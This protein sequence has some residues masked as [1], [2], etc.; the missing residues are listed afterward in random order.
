MNNLYEYLLFLLINKY[1]FSNSEYI[2]GTQTSGIGN[3]NLA[4]LIENTVENEY[5]KETY[6]NNDNS[7]SGYWTLTPD[8]NNNFLVFTIVWSGKFDTVPTS[9]SGYFGLRPVIEIEK[10]KLS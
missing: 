10:N 2:L 7:N 3:T 6:S 5:K 1:Y 9:Y 8:S 4:W